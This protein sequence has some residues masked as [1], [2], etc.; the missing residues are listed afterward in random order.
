LLYHGLKSRLTVIAKAYC[1]AF[2]ASFAKLIAAPSGSIAII[3]ALAAP[4]VLAGL[5]VAVDYGALSLKVTQLNQLADTAAVGGARELALAGS[6]E[7]SIKSIVESYIA[8][9]GKSNVSFNITI[10]RKAGTLNVALSETWTPFFA[11]I[12][13]AG[14]TPIKVQATAMLVGSSSICILALDES[15]SKGLHLDKSARVSAKNCGVYSN[16]KH[17]QGIRLDAD[18][19]IKADLVCSAGGVVAK[20][21]AISPAPTSDCPP[22]DDPLAKRAPPKSLGCDFTNFEVKGGSQALSPGT[23]CGGL[24]ITST[25]NVSFTKGT[26]I[27]QDGPF[28]VSGNSKISGKNVSFYLSGEATTL[29][30]TDQS[31]VALSGAVDGDMAGL[32]FFEDRSVSLDRNHHISSANVSELTGTI[33][34]SRGRLQVDPNAA[35]AADSAYTAI[36]AHTLELTEGPELVLNADFGSTNVP[37]PAGVRSSAQVVLTK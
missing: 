12:L 13:D 6:T 16:S 10:D 5:G 27:I 19:S 26:Y 22:A 31:S 21:T 30:L 17:K 37:V 15:A 1:Q 24:K 18:S 28:T 7:Q 4:V 35:V 2:A 33:Y 20:T 11:H 8:Q 23:Y 14:I 29:N 32:L 25:A 9:D 36:I 34:L 3:T